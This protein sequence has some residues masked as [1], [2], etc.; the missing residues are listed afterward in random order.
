MPCFARAP[1]FWAAAPP[2][3]QRASTRAQRS[4]ACRKPP[5]KLDPSRPPGPPF[6]AYTDEE[7]A[8]QRRN[9]G[10][11]P[12]GVL[13]ADALRYRMGVGGSVSG[14][15]ADASDGTM[16]DHASGGERRGAGEALG[17]LHTAAA[18]V[19]V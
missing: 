15:S 14:T 4:S 13:G 10:P 8:R 3:A 7:R 18:F 17:S 2:R 1:H 19:E 9:L 16:A 12:P 5:P 6:R 11:P